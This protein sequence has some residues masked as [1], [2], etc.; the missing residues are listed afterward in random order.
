MTHSCTELEAVAESFIQNN[1]LQVC[2]EDEFL[3]LPL[4]TLMHFLQSE[5]LRIENE[6]Q[7]FKAAMNW[8]CYDVANRRMHVFEVANC[9]RVALISEKQL[10]AYLH[11]CLDFSLKI[12]LQKYLQDFRVDRK[13][14][15]EQKLGKM[16]PYLV[17]PRK[18]A[19]KNIYV[20]GGFIRQRGGRWS[21]AHV[22]SMVERLDTYHHQWHVIP[23]IHHPRSGHGVAVL[24]RQLLVIGGESDSLIY[25]S[26]ECYDSSTNIWTAMPCLTSPRCGLAACTVNG[27][28]Y[29][30]GGWVGSEIG[31]TVEKFDPQLNIWTIVGKMPTGR[32]AM[33]V[34][35]NQGKI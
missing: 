25:D 18:A 34:A 4:D 17:Q 21:D 32:Y 11:R 6:F 27:C 23:S 29:T 8:I 3:Q 5:F 20:V 31:D 22:L 7:V 9:L 15:V 28:V 10:N 26:V 16:K 19:C 24:N 30:F 2:K 35:E 13:I 12:A 33:G 14:C 1:F